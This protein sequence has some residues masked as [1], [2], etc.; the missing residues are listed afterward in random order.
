MLFRKYSKNVHLIKD[1]A[2]AFSKALEFS[3]QEAPVLVTGSFYIVSEIR[4]LVVN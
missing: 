3:G 2:E 4:K 1:P